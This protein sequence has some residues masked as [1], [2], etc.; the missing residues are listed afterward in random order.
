MYPCEKTNT[1]IND[2]YQL[3]WKIKYIHYKNTALCKRP[4]HAALSL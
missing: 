1:E 2:S 4:F 3:P